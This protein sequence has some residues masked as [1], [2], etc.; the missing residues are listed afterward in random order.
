MADELTFLMNVDSA[1]APNNFYTLAK[2]YFVAAGSTVVD[3]PA[4][5][6][7]LEGVFEELVT[8]GVE[9]TTINL[10]SDAAG[11]AALDCPV[12]LTE[13]AAGRKVATADDLQNALANKSLA[14]PGPGIV[15]AR[16]RVVIYGCDLGRSEVFLRML[17][18]LLGAP[19]ELL[20]PRRLGLFVSDG[21]TVEYRQAQ[22]WSLI[23]KP[24]L[25]I[26]GAAAPSGGWP[27]YRA[28]FVNDAVGRFGGIASAS[29][30]TGEDDLKTML[31]T[32]AQN[33]TTTAGPSF[34]LEETVDIFPQ[35]S[36]T[37]AEAAAS[38]RPRSN[39]DPVTATPK[40]ASEVDDAALVT[41]ITG[42]DAFPADTANTRFQITVA[43]LAQVVDQ[44]VLIAEGPDYRRVTSSEGSAP[45][46]G[47]KPVDGGT[48]SGA[49]PPDAELQ[50]TVAVLLADGAAQAD[51][52]ALLAAIPQGDATEEAVPDDSDPAETWEF[53][54][55]DYFDPEEGLA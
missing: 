35:G 49:L 16:T 55:S 28:A 18:G 25:I 43:V 30:A 24:P 46:P 47:P 2:Q 29:E 5:G 41:T 12:T 26:D 27:G 42:A 50:A 51:A 7:T 53:D 33:A 34:F 4:N 10:V 15:T 8:R 44:P 13:Q 9:Q 32:A 1:G 40:T 21:T 14:A 36:Q 48:G 19:G 22:T 38:V 39:G 17:S 52:D 23:R 6:Q 11:F 3:A 20:A 45:S 37:A 31:T 54:G